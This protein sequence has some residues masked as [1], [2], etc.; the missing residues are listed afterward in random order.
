MKR[1]AFTLLVLVPLLVVSCGALWQ[2]DSARGVQAARSGEYA[3]A[4]RTLE[5]LVANGSNDA[6]FVDGLYYAWMRQGEIGRAH[7]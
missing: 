4:V 1:K 6:A 2:S 7:V 3:D 5:P